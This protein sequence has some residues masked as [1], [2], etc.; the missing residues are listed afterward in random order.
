MILK[1]FLHQLILEAGDICLEE[2]GKIGLKDV[3]FKNK[4]DL[5]TSADKK[6]EAYII[7]KIRQTF[8]DHDV[9]GEETGRTDI[10]SRYLWIID[11]I[12]GTTSF[13]HKQPFYSVSIAIQKDGETILAAVY[14]PVLNE[15][16][17]AWKNEGAFL[18]GKRI[19]VSKTDKMINSVMATGFACIRAGLEQNNLPFLNRILPQ[20]RDIRRYGSAAVDLCY[21]GCGKLDGFWEMNLN[22]YDIAAGVLIV[23]EAGGR[24]FDFNG[25]S[26]YP[27]KGIIATNSMLD[28]TLLR[29]FNG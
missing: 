24:V 12:D 19:Y 3:E 27:Q 9:F 7:S 6:V 23:T 25:N 26:Q 1:D 2:S 15:L 13:F 14:A 8:P 5:V 20:I 4:K 17:T 28:Q 29:N 18:N 10:S 16:F 22:I 11:P 21:V